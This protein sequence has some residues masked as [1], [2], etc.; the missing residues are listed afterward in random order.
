[1][2]KN[3][4][5]I[6]WRNILRNRSLAL[7]NI[8]GLALALTVAMFILLWVRHETS[9]DD[10]HAK[11]DRLYLLMN[12]IQP[13]SAEMQT[14]SGSPEPYHRVLPEE[15]PEIEGAAMYFSIPQEVKYERNTF[16]PMVY[17]A[18]PSILDLFSLPL[19]LG[20]KNTALQDPQS[21]ILS[22]DL[23]E[24]MFGPDWRSDKEVLGSV[25][26]VGKGS[27]F[28]IRGILEPLPGPS[29]LDIKLLIPI[30]AL[31][32]IDPGSRNHWGNYNFTT[33]FELAE[34]ADV[35]AVNAKL[36]PVVKAHSDRGM[37]EGMFL[38][39]LGDVYLR[40]QFTDGQ[41]S[42][43]R[44]AYVRIFS[45]AALFLLLIAAINYMN[46]VTATA[47]TRAREVGIRKVSGAPRY[48]LAGQFLTES[49]LT[50]V[51]AG[52]LAAAL[53][54]AL[55]DTFQSISGKN[56]SQDLNGA[57]F[58]LSFA[59]IGLLI[60]IL[61]GIY[62]A[63][64]LSGFRTANV[65]KGKVSDRIGGLQLRRA[66]VVLQFALSIIL[67]TAALSV[68]SQ[69]HYLKHKELGLDREQVL[70]WHMPDHINARYDVLQTELLTDPSIAAL[71]R[72]SEL[73]I[74]VETG[75]GDP[76]WE[77]MDESKRAIFKMMFVDEDFFSAVGIQMAT[78]TSFTT[79][80]IG[81]TADFRF[82]INE[83]AAR[84]MGFEDPINKRLSFWGMDGRI[85]G[86]V[87]DFH[88]ASLHTD[89]QPM[90]FHL[91]PDNANVL[92]MRSH[93]GETERAI[94]ALKTGV[95]G[96]DEQQAVNYHF[97][98]QQYEAMYRSEITTGKLAD[99]FA[100]LAIIISCLGLL[101]LAVF[102]TH[103]RIKEIGVRKVLGATVAQIAALL[104]KE[105]IVL[106]IIAFGV[107]AP[108]AG[109]LIGNW[110]GQFAYRIELSWVIFAVAGL[111]AV[112]L[113]LLTVGL[114]GVRAARANPVK[115]LRSE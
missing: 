65:L 4:L 98:D 34:G 89:I 101:G 29:I 36:R 82:I 41:V 92:F 22:A 85:I 109:Y 48:A 64:M 2:I 61:A 40:S 57:G 23:A 112:S 106:V 20:D 21:A 115:A 5:T 80:M 27:Q 26:Q 42:G 96:I 28:V 51:F 78:G 9:Y 14:W 67:I 73:P 66:L 38:H 32:A 74:R 71:G 79:E 54:S 88:H 69:V 75:T 63:F 31:W 70:A 3:F 39:P 87:K 53:G 110:L 43:G 113:A 1:M 46:L 93:S 12:N 30:D 108:V 58:W 16:E 100:I 35:E 91:W 55:L 99:I 37:P 24:Q 15:I 6:A 102:N 72:S 104:S 47:T 114:L 44:I 84:H 52:L 8:G 68:R 56:V 86:V 59:G 77:G 13:G 19:A 83:T 97:L 11:A 94:A 45:A 103:R 60:G 17:L 105:F 33:Y 62:P 76:S 10:F 49:V 111:G 25:L 107:G 95:S 81:D 7:I 18:T 50:A 90:V